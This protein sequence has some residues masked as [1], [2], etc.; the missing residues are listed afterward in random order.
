[1]DNETK[2][3]LRMLGGIVLFFGMFWGAIDGF[4]HD[5]NPY[6]SCHVK[7]RWGYL[8]PVHYITCVG[9]AFMNQEG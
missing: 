6:Q 2:E 5:Q 4:N 9:V 1:M 3:I 8:T 7:E